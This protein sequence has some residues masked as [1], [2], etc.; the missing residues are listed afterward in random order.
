M[1]R[2]LAIIAVVLSASA[3][4]GR[5]RREQGRLRQ[6]SGRPRVG[7]VY[8]DRR[9][10]RPGRPVASSVGPDRSA[11]LR[12]AHR[13]PLERITVGYG[14]DGNTGDLLLLSARNDGE[15]RASDSGRASSPNGFPGRAS[16]SESTINDAFRGD[17]ALDER[18]GDAWR[19]RAVSGR[20]QAQSLLRCA[21]DR[22]GTAERR[23]RAGTIPVLSRRWP[24][25]AAY[26]R[27]LDAGR[28]DRC[29]PDAW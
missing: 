20:G 27:Q 7:D 15:R 14:P 16:D 21:R 23:V 24:A 12:R 17:I 13:L 3:I 29:E 19:P 10:G 18:E 11:G 8:V 6:R 4:R 22:C 9:R 26:R 25:S 28:P 2:R 1:T 5:K